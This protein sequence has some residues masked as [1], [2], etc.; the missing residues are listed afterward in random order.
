MARLPKRQTLPAQAAEIL[1]EM[2]E[3][4]ELQG[5]L[6]GERT[7]AERLQIGRDTLRSALETLENEGWISP[8][9]HGK[10][11][12]IMQISGRVKRPART[13]T[14]AFLSPKRLEELPPW[15]LVELDLAKGFLARQ[16]YKLELVSPGLFHL[17][18][19]GRKLENLLA[20]TKADAWILYQCPPPVQSWFQ[21]KRVPAVIRGYPHEE[22]TLPAIDEDWHA[23]AFHGGGLLKRHGHRRVGLLLPDVKL[24]GL[25]AAE[26]GLTEAIEATPSP[27][28]VYRL[29]DRQDTE[30]VANSLQRAF[31]LDDPPTAIVVTRGRHILTL[32]SWLATRR[33]RI[34]DDVS[35]I[36]LCHEAWF[37]ALIPSINSY[38]LT[39][40]TTA[41][42][43]ARKV[44]AILGGQAPGEPPTLLIPEAIA[45][46][47]VKK[48]IPSP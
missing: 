21:E 33:L 25:A 6:P 10:R 37:E 18:S 46:R 17:Q 41:R 13:H 32:V 23:A 2:I 14:V 40:E 29:I 11:R 5:L 3:R 31:A 48:L 26:R 47:S 38:H 7:L 15:M 20:D 43:T 45:G 39:P 24:A 9:E 27:G 30:S 28:S 34:P 8:R 35:V 44:Q 16:G 4:R 22:I 42:A 1:K 36:A 19:P 12:R